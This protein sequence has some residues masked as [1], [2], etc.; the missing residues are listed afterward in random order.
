MSEPK[1]YA[2]DASAGAKWFKRE[3]GSEAMSE[4]HVRAAAG[5]I[6]LLAPM[7]FAY[8]VLSVVKRELGAVAL[9][10]AWRHILASGVTLIPL[11]DEV[12]EEAAHQCDALGCSFYD[13]LAPACAVLLGAT[14][15]SANRRA[16]G[17]FPGVLIVE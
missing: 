4:L 10:E 5:E 7:H 16:H 2:L 14:L 8:E 6:R 1:A 15:A 12:V 3:P 17:G 11:A 9:A 13:A